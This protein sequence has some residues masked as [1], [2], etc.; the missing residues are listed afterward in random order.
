MHSLREEY[1]VLQN[2]VNKDSDSLHL[3][4]F[5]SFSELQFGYVLVDIIY[6]VFK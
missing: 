2:G 4:V 1:I 3:V 6:F 5:Q